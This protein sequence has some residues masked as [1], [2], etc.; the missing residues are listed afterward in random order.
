[1]TSLE[2]ARRNYI[3]QLKTR[4]RELQEE[5]GQVEAEL[6][7]FNS[8]SSQRTPRR[9]EV[10]TGQDPRGRTARRTPA[11]R[12]PRGQRKQQV[13]RAVRK[14]GPAGPSAVAKEVGIAPSQAAN[15]LS[16]LGD[17]KAI[18]K[19]KDGWKISS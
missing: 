5:L 13:L 14:L 11:K 3:N 4:R 8:S 17:E 15:L 6:Q 12:A 2:Q 9:S 18:T 16:T 10:I 1:M 7:G 19:T